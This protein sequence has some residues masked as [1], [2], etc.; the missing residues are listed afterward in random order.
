M[1][2]AADFSTLLLLAGLTVGHLSDLARAADYRL[3][4]AESR[5]RIASI[6]AMPVLR[7]PDDPI[8]L[9]RSAAGRQLRVELDD[10]N[11]KP[12]HVLTAAPGA[13]I[14]LCGSTPAARSAFFSRVAGLEE[15]SGFA[16]FLD[17]IPL[18]K[19]SRRD[20][21]RAVTLLSPAIPL[22][23]ATMIDNIA[24]GAPSAT[25]REEIDAI[26]SLCGL[27][28]DTA[29]QCGQMREEPAPGP[30]PMQA[31]RIRGARALAR[32]AVVLLID[33]VE[34]CRDQD[35]LAAVLAYA[36]AAHTTVIVS[37]EAAPEGIQF[38]DTWLLDSEWSSRGNL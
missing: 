17:D 34:V 9:P 5:R 3:A 12:S 37:C 7:D 25:A 14:A 24:I 19:T 20:R 29:R 22:V 26:A 18:L 32:S 15:D 1:M 6:L 35:L 2:P 38:D 11:G 31:A 33:D 30:C 13:L 36:R 28:A 27:A 4:Y 10:A 21:R 23:R 8:P 16:A